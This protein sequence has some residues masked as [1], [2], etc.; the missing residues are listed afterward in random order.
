[1]NPQRTL[2]YAS[3]SLLLVASS[4]FGIQIGTPNLSVYPENRGKATLSCQVGTQE[5]LNVALGKVLQAVIQCVEG[6]FSQL[7]SP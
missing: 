4:Y 3:G 7:P 1:V 6:F 2:R 5:M